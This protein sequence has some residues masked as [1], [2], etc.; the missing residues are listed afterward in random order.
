MKETRSPSVIRAA[1]TSRAPKNR[2]II[3]TTPA[4]IDV[5][6]VTVD[7]RIHGLQHQP[8]QAMRVL[9]EDPLPRVSPRG[10]P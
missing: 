5:R 9:G 2:M 4:S 6:P 10:T 8:Q 1:I 7:N 3:P